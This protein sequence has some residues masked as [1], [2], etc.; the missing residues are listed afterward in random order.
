MVVPAGVGNKVRLSTD[1][2]DDGRACG[3]GSTA[4]TMV[5]LVWADSSDDGRAGA[6]VGHKVR[7][8]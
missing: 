8:I 3:C 6:G 4:E 5:V 2:K 1:S 7:L